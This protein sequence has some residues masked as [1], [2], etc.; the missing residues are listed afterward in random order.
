MNFLSPSESIIVF[1]IFFITNKWWKKRHKKSNNKQILM[2]FMRKELLIR[3]IFQELPLITSI[4]DDSFKDKEMANLVFGPNDSLLTAASN[5]IQNH[6]KF[7][8]YKLFVYCFDIK[9]EQI[10][11]EKCIN[12]TKS[13]NDL[14]N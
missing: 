2:Q 8:F 1:Y 11:T 4:K 3:E 6:I 13:D 9:Q 14:I 10:I 5:K 12:S 7:T